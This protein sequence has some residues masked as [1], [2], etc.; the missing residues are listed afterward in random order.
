MP[1]KSIEWRNVVLCARPCLLSPRVMYSCLT[2]MRFYQK[3]FDMRSIGRY[4]AYI[5]HDFFSNKR[6]RL[7]F[8]SRTKFLVG[9]R[10]Y[11]FIGQYGLFD[12]T[13]PL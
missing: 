13:L 7:F 9:N 12:G 10:L 2:H 11:L 8:L 3:P 5:T 6:V 1:E 4:I